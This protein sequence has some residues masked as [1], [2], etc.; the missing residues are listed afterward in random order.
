ME[1]RVRN[2][3]EALHRGTTAIQL[4][5]VSIDSRNGRT[6]EIA[7][8]VYTI[9]QAP[10]ER[11]L[12]SPDRDA[13]PFLHFFESLWMLQGREDLAFLRMFTKNFDKYSDNGATMQGSYGMRWRGWFGF[14]Q[15]NTLVDLMKK[16]PNTRRAVLQMWD[17]KFDLLLHPG[18]SDIPC[19]TTIYFK[20]RDGK[21]NMTV[22]NRSNDMIFG[23][24]G[25]NAVHM[26]FLQE[27]IAGRLGVQVG[28]MIQQSDSFHVYLDGP[29]GEVWKRV[30]EGH[31]YNRLWL[32]PYV[33]HRETYPYPMFYQTT[34][35]AVDRDLAVFFQRFDDDNKI[36]YMDFLTP[37][38]K[39][40]VTPM[41]L[42]H[43]TRDIDTARLISAPDWRKACV[44]WLERR[45]K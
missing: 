10:M 25:A 30:Q 12:V 18:S 9:Y 32:D 24:Y 7:E 40:V 20:L 19:N 44:E 41:Y 22:C 36:G 29:G 8:P 33:W 11:V 6:L 14:D 42:A 2:V 15:L 39:F 16:D 43:Q 23:A 3:L 5:G 17:P 1:L 13:N 45:V 26:S 4:H 35:Y 21:L 28:N 38:F 31:S 34:P 37:F 27:Y